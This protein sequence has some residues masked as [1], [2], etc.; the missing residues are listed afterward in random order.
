MDILLVPP[1]PPKFLPVARSSEHHEDDQ[2]VS[3]FNYYFLFLAAMGLLV[4]L[5]LWWL[6]RRRKLKKARMRRSGQTALARDLERWAGTRRFMHG[7]HG[8]D[9]AAQV[10]RQEG[11]NE[12]GEAPPPYQP[13]SEATTNVSVDGGHDLAP[14]LAI[15][16]RALTRDNGEH[17]RL[18]A[19]THVVERSPARTG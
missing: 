13:K 18:P 10:R 7:N 17:H 19:Y 2:N 4:A 15:P 3:V 16:L 11:L 5:F 12:D 8:R 14:T 9:Q 6:L 1:V